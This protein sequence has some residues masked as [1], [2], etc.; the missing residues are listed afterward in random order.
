MRRSWGSGRWIRPGSGAGTGI[1]RKT[2]S[3]IISSTEIIEK[4]RKTPADEVVR[5]YD[6]NEVHTV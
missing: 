1:M 5:G 6:P 3:G 2:A 4:T